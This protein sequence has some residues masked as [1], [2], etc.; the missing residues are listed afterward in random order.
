MLSNL[1]AHNRFTIAAF[2]MSFLATLAVSPLGASEWNKSTI[3]TF[4]APVEVPG[5]VLL[6]GAYVFETLP[7]DR[8]IVLIFDRD[9]SKLEAMT[10]A[11][12]TY[13]STAPSRTR[14]VFEERA[15]NAPQAIKAW[16]YPGDATGF[17]FVYPR[18]SQI[19]RGLS[20]GNA[21]LEHNLGD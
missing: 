4:N 17:E 14:V 9:S 11:I 13:A 6:P 12:P 19:K 1:R 21:N 15:S 20:S 3:M 18:A 5:K 16:F 2:G 10:L 8:N 7:D